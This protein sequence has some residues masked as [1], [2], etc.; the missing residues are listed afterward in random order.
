MKRRR[1]SRWQMPEGNSYVDPSGDAYSAA[2]EAMRSANAE[3]IYDADG[4]LKYVF[5]YDENGKKTKSSGYDADGKLK[6]AY[7]FDENEN[8]TKALWYGYNA[9]GKLS[10]YIVSEYDENGNKTKESCY[11]AEGNLIYSK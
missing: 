5:E 8:K 1:H 11:D 4:K 10:S 7:E 2:K 3:R 6:Y 9:D